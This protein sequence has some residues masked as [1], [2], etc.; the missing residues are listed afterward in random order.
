MQKALLGLGGLLCV[1]GALLIAANFV[2][3]LMGFGTSVNFG[4]A[5]KFEFILVPFWQ[6]GLAVAVIGGACLFGSRRLNR[7]P[8]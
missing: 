1:V 5:T 6:I 7:T 4:D 2:M 8:D 3:G